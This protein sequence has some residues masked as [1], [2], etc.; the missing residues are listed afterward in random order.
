[1]LSMKKCRT[2]TV[3]AVAMDYALTKKRKVN[4]NYV[5]NCCQGG[6]EE[7]GFSSNFNPNFK[8]LKPMYILVIGLLSFSL[9]SNAQP[10][11]ESSSSSC[12]EKLEIPFITMK[13]TDAGVSGGRSNL[14][15]RCYKERSKPE[16]V[17]LHE[18]LRDDNIKVNINNMK[19]SI[20]CIQE[21][22]EELMSPEVGKLEE[23]PQATLMKN[24]E[25]ILKNLGK[26]EPDLK[27]KIEEIRDTLNNLQS[28]SKLGVPNSAQQPSELTQPRLPCGQLDSIAADTV[29]ACGPRTSRKAGRNVTPSSITFPNE[30]SGPAETIPT[31]RE[32][33]P[34]GTPTCSPRENRSGKGTS[35]K[36]A[37]VKLGELI[38]KWSN[39][40]EKSQNLEGNCDNMKIMFEQFMDYMQ[41]KDEEL[42][43]ISTETKTKG[44]GVKEEYATM[45]K[46]LVQGLPITCKKES[47][48]KN[49][50]VQGDNS[51]EL[52]SCT[53]CIM[54]NVSIKNTFCGKRQKK[55]DVEYVFKAKD[56]TEMEKYGGRKYEYTIEDWRNI[57]FKWRGMEKEI[58]NWLRENKDI[59]KKENDRKSN[60]R[61]KSK[62]KENKK[63]QIEWNVEK[64]K[65]ML[66]PDWGKIRESVDQIMK[67]VERQIQRSIILAYKFLKSKP[68]KGRKGQV[69]TTGEK[70][71][72]NYRI[73][74]EITMYPS[75]QVEHNNQGDQTEPQTETAESLSS[76]ATPIPEAKGG[77]GNPPRNKIHDGPP[78]ILGGSTEQ[79]GD[80]VSSV[81]V[82]GEKDSRAADSNSGNSALGMNGPV[83]QKL[84]IEFSGPKKDSQRDTE[85]IVVDDCSENPAP[86]VHTKKSA[87]EALSRRELRKRKMQNL[88]NRM[89]LM[90]YKVL[91][92][93]GF[94]IFIQ[95]VAFTQLLLCISIPGGI[96][97][98]ICGKP[99]ATVIVAF[100]AAAKA[101]TKG[102]CSG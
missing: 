30:G 5:P 42:S 55:E 13:D 78:I 100:T 44:P 4:R 11:G 102:M 50:R 48:D 9:Q 28:S 89:K 60:V 1:M 81:G 93:K 51:R 85:Y 34:V 99:G 67:E 43:A 74:V 33:P 62:N 64:M 96:I 46:C 71:R 72:N 88:R 21:K 87:P 86:S 65:Q 29:P 37:S 10:P 66:K 91:L 61:R 38:G 31:S 101:A 3:P 98:P 69:G 15:N 18:G 77:T 40:M 95:I 19:G 23:N 75:S 56:N 17:N 2:R 14:N 73:T 84:V 83:I 36:D 49:D 59:I 26:Y 8:I 22:E 53:Q 57:Q 76:P 92:N 24:I 90:L 45:C 6:M 39:Y 7:R 94:I 54:L 12:R 16:H 58:T 25:D 52:I 32:S 70:Q 63:V 47:K 80:P 68:D 20:G 79:N 41:E 27:G 82:T 97:I 35:A